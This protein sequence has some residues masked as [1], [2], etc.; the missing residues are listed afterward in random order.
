MRIASCQA[1]PKFAIRSSNYR[2][3]EELN[4]FCMYV[5]DSSLKSIFVYS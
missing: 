2:E 3:A 4:T 5:I 1:S